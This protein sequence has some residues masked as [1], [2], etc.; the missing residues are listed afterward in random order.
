MTSL[1]KAFKTLRKAGYIAK[2]NF[3]CC[4]SCGWYAI[5]EELRAKGADDA[6]IE[7]AK[8]VFYHSQDAT[9]LRKTGNVYLAWAGDPTEI[10]KAFECEGFE[11][12]HNGSEAERIL[13]KGVN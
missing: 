8:I 3:T 13:I 6:A 11:V 4:S 2:Q 5:A 7:G 9:N 12:E 1:S 10:R